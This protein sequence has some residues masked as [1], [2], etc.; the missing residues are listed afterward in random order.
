MLPFYVLGHLYWHSIA[1]LFLFALTGSF[2]SNWIQLVISVVYFSYAY[3]D[4]FKYQS[5]LKTLAKGFGVYLTTQLLFGLLAMIMVILLIVLD[6][7]VYEMMRPS[8]NQ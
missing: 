5:R 8:N 4:L 1:S 2:L 6:P 7:Q 3:S